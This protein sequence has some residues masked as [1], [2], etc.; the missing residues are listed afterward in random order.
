[1]PVFAG[2]GGVCLVHGADA[3]LGRKKK[4]RYVFFSG[5]P[6]PPKKENRPYPAVGKKMGE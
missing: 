1:M 6:I 3:G 2:G 5:V 4:D